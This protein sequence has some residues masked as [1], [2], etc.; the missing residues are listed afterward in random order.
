MLEHKDSPAVE[1]K[2]VLGSLEEGIYHSDAV[3][4]CLP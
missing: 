3:R 4:D 2:A 1:S